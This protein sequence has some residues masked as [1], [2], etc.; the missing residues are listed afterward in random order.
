[1]TK[2]YSPKIHL[3][4]ANFRM[5]EGLKEVKKFRNYLP[6]I[7]FSLTGVI[8][9]VANIFLVDFGMYR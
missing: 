5:L 2:H 7:N 3:A 1:M 6:A 4:I 8:F 9:A